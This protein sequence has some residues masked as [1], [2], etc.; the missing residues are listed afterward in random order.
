MSDWSPPTVPPQA[1][2]VVVALYAAVVLYSVVVV[3][4]FLPAVFVG[5]LFVTAYFAYRLLM[6]IEAIADA[7]Q[8]MANRQEP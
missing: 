5:L 2:P 3:Q 4:R 1:L 7:Q 8:R 6:A